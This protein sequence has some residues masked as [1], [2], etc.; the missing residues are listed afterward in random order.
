MKIEFQIPDS[1]IDELKNDLCRLD[2]ILGFPCEFQVII[3]PELKPSSRENIR[4][5]SF[6]REKEVQ[7]NTP[8]IVLGLKYFQGDIDDRILILLHE[9]IHCYQRI[10]E[11]RNLNEKYAINLVDEINLYK[12]NYKNN[13]DSKEYYVFHNSLCAVYM[14]S[15]WIFEIWDE[16][17]LKNNYI[18][19]FEH[20]LELTFK[21]IDMNIDEQ[22]Y[23]DYGRWK[24][25]LI[26]IDLVRAQ[27]LAK[28]CKGYSVETK[29]QNLYDR[30]ENKLKDI[31]TTTD[32]EILI[33]QL[34]GL[35]RIEDYNT[36]NTSILE[37]S[38]DRLIKQ[39]II[40]AKIMFKG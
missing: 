23:K 11:L 13:Y 21:T 39:M 40:D 15:T 34:D 1:K 22:I 2:H 38:Y 14:F 24:K 18:K 7:I 29:F 17:Y 4:P 25:Y 31:T 9:I 30:W 6:F 5:R 10:G 36:S 26:F 35:T 28:I 27:Y 3:T 37:E 8:L 12:N 20:K 32:F 19:I 33:N 16:M